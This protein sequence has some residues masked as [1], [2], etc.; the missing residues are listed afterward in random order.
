[1]SR[2]TAYAERHTTPSVRDVNRMVGSNGFCGLICTWA[3][4][5]WAA[6]QFQAMPVRPTVCSVASRLQSW[7]ASMK[8][9]MR[10]APGRNWRHRTP[11]LNRYWSVT[12]SVRESTTDQGGGS[13]GIVRATEVG[14]C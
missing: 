11:P 3:G 4:S 10:G 9:G 6:V 13:A 8:A 2:T 12:P 1:M 5:G 14:Y 7:G